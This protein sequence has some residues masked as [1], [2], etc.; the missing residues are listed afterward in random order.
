MQVIMVYLI[1]KVET[2]VTILMAN[3]ELNKKN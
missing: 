1:K 3:K 2:K